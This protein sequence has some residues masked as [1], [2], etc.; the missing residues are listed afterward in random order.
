MKTIVLAATPLALTGVALLALSGGP[1]QAQTSAASIANMR[2]EY[3]TNPLSIDATKP[4]LSWTIQAAGRGWRQSAYRLQVASSAQNLAQGKADLWDSGQIKSNKTLGV[5]YAGKPMGSGARAFWR[6]QVWD[7]AGKTSPWSGVGTW[8]LALL[9]P[10]DWKGQWISAPLPRDVQV[11]GIKLAPSP[12]LRKTFA[13]TKPIKQAT[14]FATARGVY[15]LRLN[16]SKVG[17]ELLAPGWTDYQTRMQCQAY[18]VTKQ[19]KRGQNAIGAI[20][21]DGWFSGYVGFGARRDHYGTTT[22][23]QAQLD[24]QYTDG[25][26][27][28]VSTDTSWQGGAGPIQYS[29]MLQGEYYDA[30]KEQNGW[31]TADFKATGWKSAIVVAAP[32]NTGLVDVT[33]FAKAAVKNGVFSLRASN[34]MAG[35]PAFNTVKR[36]KV[37]YTLNGVAG[38]RTI[39]ENQTLQF[40]NPGDTLVIVRAD[41]GAERKV[42]GPV[43][44]VGTHDP[45]IRVTQD[46][47]PIKITEPTPGT[48]IYDMGQN[49]V[50]VVRLKV[51]APAGTAVKMRFA[52]MLNPD[53]TAYTANLRSA[54]ATDTYITKG[55]SVETWEPRFTFHGFRYVEVTGFPG[56]PAL[57]T[58]TG[59]VIGSD[60]VKTGNFT[61]SSP[62]V[63][64][65]QKNIDWGQRGNFLSVPTDCPQR[66]ERLG[67][68]GD[69]QVFVRTATYNRDVS[70]FFEKWM[71]DVEDGQALDGGYSDVS[72][73]KVDE[74]N[75]APAWG[76][77]GVIVPWTVYQAYG[78]TEIIDRHWNSMEKWMTYLTEVNPDG[79][80]RQRRGNDFGDWL[81]I[82]AN[83]PK[84]VLATGYYAYDASLMAKMARATGRTAEA[85]KYDALFQHIKTAFNREFVTGDG[86]IKGQTQTSYLVGLKFNLLPEN[87]RPLAAQHLVADIASKNDHLSTGFVGVG[88]LCPT[89]SDTGHNETA[90]KLLLNDT[91]PSWGF[92]IRHG[93][94]T[95][96]ER[97]DGWTPDKGFQDVGM[98]SFNH[99]SLGSVGEWL[100]SHVAG[101]STDPR[102]PGFERI[103]IEPTPG[104]GLTYANATYNSVRGRIQSAWKKQGNVL[105]LDVTIPANTSA[106]V[107]IP[108]KNAGVV[109]EGT[110]LAS[111]APGVKF[112]RQEGGDTF[113]QV[114]SGTYKFTTN[115][116]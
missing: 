52:E 28:I 48:F 100:Y 108:A 17:N 95:I 60:T 4:R 111:N 2:C 19:L 68:M 58:I 103:L 65:L 101:I 109:K 90:Y 29:D 106:T 32:N 67:W 26:H 61:C 92:S 102:Y 33:S 76:D 74:A 36:M 16:G 91:F 96:W 88:Y 47:K 30:R 105:T 115:V 63:N 116:S 15:E 1:V 14:L 37:D 53:G 18:D 21:G 3:L 73:R 113:F 71:Q 45:A 84:D 69:A 13:L 70:A 24:V 107:R 114:G 20:I 86:Q 23:I 27:Q 87:L 94:T 112:M 59:R 22:S 34:D 25:T 82:G 72:P 83:T 64:Q 93:A 9:R 89:L 8:G 54:R 6:V 44:L 79:I 81:S 62:L 57:D 38:S 77:A 5:R 55:G 10:T 80:W 7:G 40:G 11:S 31:D 75:G 51:N 66:D 99:Y 110:V 85:A 97:W 42:Q 98:N 12:F 46:V 35:D 49:M 104:T 50:G 78:D 39:P 56:R 43:K 41:Y